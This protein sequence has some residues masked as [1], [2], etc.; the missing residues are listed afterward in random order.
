MIRLKTKADIDILTESG[1]RLAAI[2]RQ[3]ADTVAPSV[4]TVELDD[5]ARELIK[6]GGDQPA[7]LNYRPEGSVLAYPAALCVSINDEVVHGIPSKRVIKDGDVVG[8]DLGLSHHG[9]FTDMA[10]TLVVGQTNPEIKKLLTVTKEALNLGIAAACAG[11]YTG[12]IGQ[13]IESYVK[14]NSFTI[15]EELSGHGVGFAP[16][17]DPLVPNFGRRGT[18][19]KL[20]PGM[21]IAIE[22]MVSTGSGRIKLLSDGFTFVTGD[23]SISAHFEH[24]VL[25]T[26]GEAKILTSFD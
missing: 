7:F 1:R 26:E 3:I 11:N 13:A 21:V 20:T 24:T 16:H 18:G 2:V 23:G 4:T 6:K 25:I 5:L 15:V 17:E 14:K 12:D 22:P 8:V 9:R 19:T 10:I